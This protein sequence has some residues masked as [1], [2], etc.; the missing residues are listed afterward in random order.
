MRNVARL[1]ESDR[2][3]LFRITADKMGLND[4]GSRLQN[5]VLSKNLG[6]V[7]ASCSWH[8]KTDSTGLSIC[9]I[10]RRLRSNE[11]YALW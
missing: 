11:G 10:D 8:F 3:E 7:P 4:A 9:S 1:S 6:K 5:E 2:R